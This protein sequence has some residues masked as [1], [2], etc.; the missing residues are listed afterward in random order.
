MDGISLGEQCATIQ[1]YGEGAGLSFTPPREVAPISDRFWQ[2]YPMGGV[3]VDGGVSGGIPIAERPAGA[4]FMALVR[5]GHIGHVIAVSLDRL[6]RSTKDIAI[7]R[8][9]LTYHGVKLHLLDLGGQTSD[10]PGGHMLTGIMAEAAQLVRA[11]IR[12][13]TINVLNGKRIKSEKLGGPVPYGQSVYLD[14]AGV[15][16]LKP[17]PKEQMVIERARELRALNM[18]YIRVGEQLIKEGYRPRTGG[19]WH[20]EPIRRMIKGE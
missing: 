14:A 12:E 16:C 9:E 20:H 13:K 1:R 3:L 18:S 15:K 6:S 19:P 5:S 10:T 8:D 11:Q 7:L 2:L 17:D 4:R